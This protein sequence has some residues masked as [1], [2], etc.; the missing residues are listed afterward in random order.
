MSDLAYIVLFLLSGGFFAVHCSRA[1]VREWRAG[2]ALGGKYGDYERE[3]EP[4]GFWM[5][6]AGNAL[7]AL[8]GNFLLL[9]GIVG[10]LAYFGWAK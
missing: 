2:Q 4:V 3:K 7:A 10:L 5:I 9:F 6:M 1:T 8:F